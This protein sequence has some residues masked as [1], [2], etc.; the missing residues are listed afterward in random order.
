[1]YNGNNGFLLGGELTGADT[2][3]TDLPRNSANPARA[4]IGDPRND[5]N[6]IVSQLQGLFLRFHN[7]T[8]ADNPKLEFADVQKLVRFHYQYVVLN[9]FL[10]RIVHSS[11]L[12]QLK[13]ASGHY[14]ERK[15]KFFRWKHE[16][17]MPIEFS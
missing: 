2:N 7:R 9:D 6:S 8:L 5:E 1:M 17:F 12:N 3:A 10:P 13:S 16:P 15:I 14:D 4:L 11:V